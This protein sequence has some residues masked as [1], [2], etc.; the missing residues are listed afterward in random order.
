M[1]P[2]SAVLGPLDR[3]IG[4][5]YRGPRQHTGIEGPL[6]MY[7]NAV[8]G[9]P[10]SPLLWWW[11]PFCCTLRATGITLHQR[12]PP[13]RG[14]SGHPGGPCVR[15]RGGPG[16]S[17]G[18]PRARC[19][20]PSS[21]YR[22]GGGSRCPGWSSPG[23]PGFQAGLVPHRSAD[24]GRPR[25]QIRPT[26][27]ISSVRAPDTASP[28]APDTRRHVSSPSAPPTSGEGE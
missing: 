18:G 28:R 15:C 9:P 10:G 7:W 19:S 24:P 12:G 1:N 2:P 3:C 8:Q 26:S 21:R 4:V 22:L 5:Q 13:G 11:G 27:A 6:L 14:S 25:D 16:L 23:L 20:S 17:P